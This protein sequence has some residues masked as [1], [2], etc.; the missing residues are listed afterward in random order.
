MDGTSFQKTWHLRWLC[1]GVVV[2][3]LIVIELEYR[4]P[5]EVG[6]VVCIGTERGYESVVSILERSPR[7]RCRIISAADVQDELALRGFDVL[8]VPGGSA[9]Q[10]AEEL[11]PAGLGNIRQFVRRGGG[12]CGICAGAYLAMDG[13]GRWLGMLNA[14][15]VR[16]KDVDVPGWGDRKSVV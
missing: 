13:D 2:M 11:G 3:L 5:I 16:F 9:G 4:G 6:I 12:Y 1:V 10:Q 8:V 7:I 15:Y 14:D